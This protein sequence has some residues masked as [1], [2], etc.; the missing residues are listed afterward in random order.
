MPQKEN[1]SV[2]K[3]DCYVQCPF[4]FYLQYVLGNYAYSDSLATEFGTAV[5]K[6]EEAIAICI[7][8]KESI[9]YTGIKNNFL[10]KCVAL[11]RKYSADFFTI[12][13]KSNMSYLDKMY[14]YLNSAIYR[15][16]AT[17]KTNPTYEIV[18]IEE[19]FSFDYDE[20]HK[21]NGAIDLVIHDLSTDEYIINDTKTWSAPKPK[22]ELVAPLQFVVYALAVEHLYGAEE[23]K[24]R[25][26][27]NLPL[28]DLYQPGGSSGFIDI[29][30][31]KINSI[32]ASIAEN[33]FTPKISPLCN[34]CSFCRQNPCADE[35]F[36]Y[37]CPYH[38]VWDR[39]TR[40]KFDVCRAETEWLGLWAHDQVLADYKAKYNIV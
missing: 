13:K 11:Q 15:L 31:S 12:D 1:Y 14:I 40:N 20:L 7:K 4:K 8:N 37:L 33:E 30:K 38:S 6:A 26:Q 35:Q 27:Y 29:G 24:I 28:L 10:L 36:K 25:C 19:R 9:N 2:S 22:S 39:Y 21:F 17:M 18:G 23:S 34:W 16:E 32:L 5:H 3:T